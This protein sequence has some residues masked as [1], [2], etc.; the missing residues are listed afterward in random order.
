VITN[1]PTYEGPGGRAWATTRPRTAIAL[2]GFLLHCPKAHPFWEWHTLSIVSLADFPGVRPAFKW[3]PDATHELM[4]D[5]VDPRH[6]PRDVN[7][8][9]MVM[10]PHDVLLQFKASDEFAGSLATKLAQDCTTGL[11]QP[12][13]D[14]ARSWAVRLAQLGAEPV[15]EPSNWPGFPFTPGDTGK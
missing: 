10:T 12:D 15:P 14:F 6:E 5:A 3:S 11:L 7:G 13:S 8:P 4:V 2:G 9:H 1:P